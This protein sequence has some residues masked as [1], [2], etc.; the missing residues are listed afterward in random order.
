M[1]P[2]YKECTIAKG[3]DLLQRV[4]DVALV[5]LRTNKAIVGGVFACE[6]PCGGTRYGGVGTIDI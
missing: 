6:I 5:S 4:L 2:G 1:T 3:N